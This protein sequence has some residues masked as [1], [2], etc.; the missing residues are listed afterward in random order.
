MI[1]TSNRT[2]MA[3]IIL[4]LAALLLAS[5]CAKAPRHSLR[6]YARERKQPDARFAYASP[7]EVG[8]DQKKLDELLSEIDAK[9]LEIHSVSI[10]RDGK[11]VMDA[12][13]TPRTTKVPLL[14]N[15]WHDLNGLAHGIIS[16]CICIAQDDGAFPAGNTPVMAWFAKDGVKNRSA[17]KDALTIDD[18]LTMRSG[19]EWNDEV[20][21]ELLGK[22]PNGA[23]EALDRPMVA[24]PGKQWRYSDGDAQIISEIFKSRSKQFCSHFGA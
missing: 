14:P 24:K 15:N 4:V 17:D 3:S 6:D 5:S 7:R 18:L 16:L 8:M 12:Y 10:I 9:N 21:S 19:L 13:G 1:G 11:L 20:D 22:K 23:K 2:P